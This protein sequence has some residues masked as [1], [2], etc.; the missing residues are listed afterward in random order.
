[1]IRTNGLKTKYK[2]LEAVSEADNIYI[3]RWDYAE[4]RELDPETEE[5]VDTD[6]AAWAEEI[7]LP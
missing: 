1:M 6:I 7:L 5:Y 2:P 4:I 3:V